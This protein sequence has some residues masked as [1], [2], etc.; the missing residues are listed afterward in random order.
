[1]TEKIIKKENIEYKLTCN[2]YIEW[3][4]PA[5]Y[6]FR[7]YQREPGKRKWLDLKGEECKVC[8]EKDIVLKHGKKSIAVYVR[9]MKYVSI[10]RC[11]ATH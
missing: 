10:S 6:R 2:L 3:S 5:K 4:R 11:I 8:T 7:L 1:M 9:I